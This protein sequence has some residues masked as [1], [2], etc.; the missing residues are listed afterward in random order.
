MGSGDLN[1]LTFE[2]FKNE[3]RIVASD[4][5]RILNAPENFNSILR[6]IDLKP[7]DSGL[8]SCI[9]KNAFGQDKISTKLLVKGKFE[10]YG[11]ELCRRDKSKL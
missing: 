1:G 7:D 6:V 4:R 10:L 11:E 3:W 8:Y 2:W 5:H 9:A